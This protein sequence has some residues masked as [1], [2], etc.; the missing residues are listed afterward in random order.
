MNGL[1]KF[2]FHNRHIKQLER[3][4]LLP[5]KNRIQLSVAYVFFSLAVGMLIHIILKNISPL[6]YIAVVYCFTGLIATVG[7]LSLM[8]SSVRKYYT[9]LILFVSLL[10][11][12]AIISQQYFFSISA[13]GISTSEGLSIPFEKFDWTIIG[14]AA[15]ILIFISVAVKM[16]TQVVE[17]QSE[18]HASLNAELLIAEKIQKQLVPDILVRFSTG[19]ICG[20]CIPAAQTGGDFIDCISLSDGRYLAVI[21]DVSGHGIGAA[22]T[23]A[24]VKGALHA[25]AESFTDLE[26]LMKRLNHFIFENSAKQTFVSM[27]ALVVDEGNKALEYINAGHMPGLIKDSVGAI[28][29]FSNRSLVLG[30]VPQAEFLSRK[31]DWSAPL[32]LLLYTD[33]INE[34][35]NVRNE[36]FGTERIKNVL[37][38]STRNPSL[39]L[40]EMFSELSH[41]STECKDDCT[42]LCVSIR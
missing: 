15:A 25:L 22:V 32:D 19:E 16:Y 11:A 42:L 14:L 7:S 18:R 41:F 27:T 39:I 17:F 9:I 20:R 8:I 29:E 3:F 2:L 35:T 1:Q 5:I 4:S 33:G 30:I 31:I 37:R 13:L 40:K 34:A 23:M 6:P 36:E 21:G 28:S 26:T 38:T 12:V 24:M 10:Y